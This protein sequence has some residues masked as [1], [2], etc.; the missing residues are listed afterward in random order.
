MTNLGKSASL[1]SSSAKKDCDGAAENASRESNRT[2]KKTRRRMARERRGAG[3]S[4][5]SMETPY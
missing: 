5:V 2:K 4:V 1:E 3:S